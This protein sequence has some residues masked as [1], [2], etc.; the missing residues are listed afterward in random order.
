MSQPESNPSTAEEIRIGITGAC[1]MM[2]KDP[3]MRREEMERL[4]NLEANQKE[5]VS[6]TKEEIGLK[7]HEKRLTKVF[8]ISKVTLRIMKLLDGVKKHGD[9]AAVLTQVNVLSEDL[10]YCDKDLVT[11]AEEAK[12]SAGQQR[13]DTGSIFDNTSEGQRR[14]GTD[15]EPRLTIATPIAAEPAPTPGIPLS[16]ALAAYEAAKE[17]WSGK[18]RKPKTLKEA[19][20]AVEA[21]EKAEVE[22]QAA[23]PEQRADDFDQPDDPGPVHPAHQQ[24]HEDESEQPQAASDLDDELPPA[25]PKKGNSEHRGLGPD[26]YH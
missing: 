23:E 1:L 4:H 14:G 13:D 3:A 12:A 6:E 22:R 18:G 7:A 24:M 20:A 19:E 5:A 16:E 26:A 21:A 8:G 9:R 11:L 10:G 17:A 15:A 2:P 25:A